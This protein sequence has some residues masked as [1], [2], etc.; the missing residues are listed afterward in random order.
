MINTN[1]YLAAKQI[2]GNGFIGIEEI[3]KIDTLKFI[4]NDTI[5]EIPFSIEELDEK[6]NDYL[7]ILGLEKLIDG[8]LVTI[9]NLVSIFGKDPQ[10]KEPCFYN[11]DWYSNEDF[12]DVPMKNKW[13]LIRKQGYNNSR[14]VL[15]QILEQQYSFPSAIECTYSFFISWLSLNE[16]LWYNDFIWCSDTD[17]NGDKIYVGRYNDIDGVN[18]N[19][20][21]IHRHLSLRS[22]YCCIDIK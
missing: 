4:I 21:N 12:I 13:I 17:H 20:F 8:R 18:K 2:M 22:C 7:L 9:R 3:Q 6:K 5:P 19:G 11:Q 10:I 16:K 15:P 1:K 14:A